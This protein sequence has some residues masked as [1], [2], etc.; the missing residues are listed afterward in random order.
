MTT[1]A[2]PITRT[3]CEKRA[4]SMVHLALREINAE[5]SGV[6]RY[7]F[8]KVYV[9]MLRESGLSIWWDDRDIITARINALHRK[10]EV[11]TAFYDRA[12]GNAAELWR[13]WANLFFDEAVALSH[14]RA[15]IVGAE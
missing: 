2:I 7:N 10:A 5:L 1:T 11:C 13:S 4:V 6:A 14:L 3:V 8:E 12:T 9:Q 15:E